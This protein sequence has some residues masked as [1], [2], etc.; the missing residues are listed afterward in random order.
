MGR[1]LVT[2]CEFRNNAVTG[3]S[4]FTIAANNIFGSPRLPQLDN[5]VRLVRG[6]VNEGRIHCFIERPN[7][8]TTVDGATFDLNSKHYLLLAKGY[9]LGNN[10]VGPHG[11]LYRAV[12]DGP[13]LL[14]P[15][16][17]AAAGARPMTIAHGALM[18]IAWI[19]TAAIGIFIARFFKNSW[20]GRKVCGT[21][22][23]F[24]W[25][26]FFQIITWI[27]TII[28][29]ILIFV[30]VGE[31]RTTTHSILGMIVMSFAILQPIVA[32]FRP[33]PTSS[34][35]PIFNFVHKFFGNFTHIL[36]FITIYFAVALPGADLV[37]W[38]IYIIIAFV[39]F[40]FLMQLI[41]GVS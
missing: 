19:G 41:L 25:H 31:W 20:I 8:V 10:M 27:L 2:E 40:Y 21:E 1:D 34:R 29:I 28:A 35:R 38:T 15:G 22:V 33:K 16:I 37:D 18:I 24:F 3:H 30:D 9:S 23:W 4:S 14:T 39:A 32:I 12:S 6:Q 5:T 26:T 13:T 11:S 17:V 36:A 7:N